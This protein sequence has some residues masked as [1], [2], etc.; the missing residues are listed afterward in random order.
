[1]ISYTLKES[2]DPVIGT[3]CRYA[4]LQGRAATTVY[5]RRK[6]LERL[7]AWLPVPLAEATP[8][9]LLEWRASLSYL[10]SQSVANYVSD[11][12]VFFE[13]ARKVAKLRDDNPAAQIPVPKPPRRLPRPISAADLCTA[14]TRAPRD[15]RAWL[16]LAVFAGLRPKEIALLRRECILDHADVPVILIASDATKGTSERMIPLLPFVLAELKMAGL[17]ASGWLFA[18]RDGQRGPNAPG[19]ISK[20]ASRYLRGCGIEATL[21][22]GRHTFAT[23]ALEASGYD[24]LTVAELLGHKDVNSTRIYVLVSQARKARVMAALPVPAGLQLAA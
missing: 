13:W 12:R 1:M 5:I 18:R 23:N 4:R 3:Y 16:I 6:G 20:R 2:S 24:L 8:E 19:T 21:H 9:M 7:A 22:Q 17:P 11:A 15:I 14:I 10:C